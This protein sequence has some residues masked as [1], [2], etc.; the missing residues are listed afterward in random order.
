MVK[1]SK[2]QTKSYRYLGIS[3]E[4]REIFDDIAS[5]YSEKIDIE[6][7]FSALALFSEHCVRVKKYFELTNGRSPLL[8][9]KNMIHP[10]LNAISMSEKQINYQA[11]K[12]GL[13]PDAR[14]KIKLDLAE[15]NRS[16]VRTGRKP[17]R[18]PTDDE[19]REAA[20]SEFI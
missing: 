20:E 16:S 12:L 3:D 4:A 7:D 8:P 10:I 14:N 9:G 19:L 15:I 13:T 17:N 18:K 2:S 1:K 11:A 5:K 6:L